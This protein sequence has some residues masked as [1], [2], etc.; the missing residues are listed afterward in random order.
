MLVTPTGWPTT[1][2]QALAWCPYFML[3]RSLVVAR[4]APPH[5]PRRLAQHDAVEQLHGPLQAFVARGEDVLVLDAQRAVVAGHAQGGDDVAPHA[6]AVTV[7]HRPERP[8][9]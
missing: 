9:A 4:S 3:F 8:G 6:L 1:P 2:P 7:A 5:L